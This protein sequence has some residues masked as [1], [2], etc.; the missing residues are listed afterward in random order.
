MPVKE[1]LVTPED[2]KEAVD[3][4]AS[5]S[6]KR[7]HKVYGQYAKRIAEVL[8]A[9]FR[10]GKGD[11]QKYWTIATRVCGI[12]Y[13][14]HSLEVGRALADSLGREMGVRDAARIAEVIYANMDYILGKKSEMEIVATRAAARR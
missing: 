7:A 1:I 4:T 8:R 10:I 2:Y 12:F 5:A 3:V 14:G 11:W 6:M 9:N 13:G